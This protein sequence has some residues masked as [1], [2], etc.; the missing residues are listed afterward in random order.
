MEI[1]ERIN[2]Y[3]L[4][5]FVHIFSTYIYF[6]RLRSN[7]L[8][9]SIFGFAIEHSPTSTLFLCFKPSPKIK[10]ETSLALSNHFH[11]FFFPM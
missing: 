3:N 11:Y 9:L 10:L 2:N 4:K 8:F 1:F 6:K 7:D 5:D